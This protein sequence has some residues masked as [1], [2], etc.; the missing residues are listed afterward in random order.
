MAYLFINLK[1]ELFVAVSLIFCLSTANKVIVL[2]KK[3]MKKVTHNTLTC[4]IGPSAGLGW[5][6]VERKCGV[7]EVGC[8]GKCGVREVWGVEGSLGLGRWGVGG[9]LGLGRR[10]VG[11]RCGVLGRWCVVA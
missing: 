6:G 11:Y 7:R 10:G 4:E 3:R 9:S 8:R 5:W 2:P 1:Y